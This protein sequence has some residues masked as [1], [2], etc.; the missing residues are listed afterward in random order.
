MAKINESGLI[1]E[2]KRTDLLTAYDVAAEMNVS[3][4]TVYYWVND[5]KIEMVNLTADKKKS[6][7]VMS[8]GDFESFRN[9]YKV[10]DFRGVRS[11]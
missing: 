7:F 8:R 10:R 11:G 6:F 9:S 2:L 4:P 1:E 3:I 5:G